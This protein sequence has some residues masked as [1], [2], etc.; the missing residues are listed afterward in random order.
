MRAPR[1]ATFSGSPWLHVHT[2]L[3]VIT[4]IENMRKGNRFAI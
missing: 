3:R 1:T 4:E 2:N